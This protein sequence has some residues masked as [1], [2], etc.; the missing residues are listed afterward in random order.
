MSVLGKLLDKTRIP[1]M[2]LLEFQGRREI[3]TLDQ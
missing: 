2:A 3:V 1:Q